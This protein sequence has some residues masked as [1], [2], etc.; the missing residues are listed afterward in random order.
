MQESGRKMKGGGS[1]GIS[2]MAGGT[3]IDNNRGNSRKAVF[4][5]GGIKQT[6]FHTGSANRV[7]KISHGISRILDTITNTN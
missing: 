7:V 3:G 2:W 1:I 4:D 6:Q 5:E